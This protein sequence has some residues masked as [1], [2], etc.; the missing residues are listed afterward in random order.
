MTAESI[1]KA[2]GGHKA[3][4][5]WV[6]RCPPMTTARRD[7]GCSLSARSNAMR[8]PTA[9]IRRQSAGSSRRASSNPSGLAGACSSPWSNHDQKSKSPFHPRTPFLCLRRLS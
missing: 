9:F 4:A 1:A 3:D 8:L 2:L 5:G 6:A 7:G